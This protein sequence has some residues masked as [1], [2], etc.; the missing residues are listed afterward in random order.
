MHALSEVMS[1]NLKGTVH[2]SKPF[3]LLL[4]YLRHFSIR[5]F[6][7]HCLRQQGTCI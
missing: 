5:I 2:A 6:V 4:T 3:L 1:A 7:R